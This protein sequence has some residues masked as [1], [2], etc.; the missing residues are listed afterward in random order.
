[1]LKNIKTIKCPICGCTEIV[2]EQ[3][4]TTCF[5]EPEIRQHC[6]GTRW[7][8]RKF[9]CGYEIEYVPNYSKELVSKGSECFYNPKVIA[10]KEKE[11]QDREKLVKI[12]EDNNISQKFIDRVKL[13]C[14][15]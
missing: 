6:C 12:L 3:I 5:N 9:L 10:R 8:H 7:E 14:L 11:K 13:C 15:Y 4:E 2:E 1:M